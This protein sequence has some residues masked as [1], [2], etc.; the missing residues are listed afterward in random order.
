MQ[1]KYLRRVLR[2]DRETPN[3]IVREGVQGEQAESS[4]SGKRAAKFDDKMDG[5][6]ECKI[7]TECCIEKK[8]TRRIR[9]ERNTI[10]ERNGYA[11]E[12]VERLR[13]KGRSKNV[14]L[15]NGDKDTNK[16]ERKERIR[17]SRYNRKYEKYVTDEIPKY[18]GESVQ[19]KVK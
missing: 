8:K 14:E 19:K 13:A 5:R 3:H 17:E 7:L 11:S 16:Q 18:L 10:R 2:V 4:S 9:K 1:E 12:E 15:S 6:E